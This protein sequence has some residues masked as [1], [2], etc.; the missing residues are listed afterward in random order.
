LKQR[1]MRRVA[2][3]LGDYIHIG[4][5]VSP[6]AGIEA[7]SLDFEFP[8][9]IW[10]WYRDSSVKVVAIIDKSGADRIHDGSPIHLE[11]VLF[12]CCSVDARVQSAS[13]KCA[14]VDD[15]YIDPSRGD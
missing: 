1:A 8:N 13:S 4:T 7:R 10:I 9:C 3:G 5:W 6:V 15:A 2:T 14:P 12:R 11:V